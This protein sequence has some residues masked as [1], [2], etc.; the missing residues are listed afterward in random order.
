MRN[1]PS[2]INRWEKSEI[3]GYYL[4]HLHWNL[5]PLKCGSKEPIFGGNKRYEVDQE[6]LLAHFGNGANF[7]LFPAGDHVVLDLDSKQDNG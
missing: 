1:I 3:A 7:G 2:A 5:T 4:N 6:E